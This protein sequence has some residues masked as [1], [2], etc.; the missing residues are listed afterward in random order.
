LTNVGVQFGRQRDGHISMIPKNV[1]SWYPPSGAYRTAQNEPVAVI[2]R[3][4]EPT[5][6]VALGCRPSGNAEDT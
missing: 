3:M 2:D 4:L 1:I 5:P 6:V